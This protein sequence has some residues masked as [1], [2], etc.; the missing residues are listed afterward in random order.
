M[1]HSLSVIRM[2]FILSVKRSIQYRWDFIIDGLLS[3][4][5]AVLQLLPLLVLF[6]ERGSI[7]G[8]SFDEMLVLMGWYMM[9]TATVEGLISPSLS[10]AM[11]GI[12]TGLFDYILIRPVDSLFLCSL[13]D[14]RLWKLIDFFFGLGLIIYALIQLDIQPSIINVAMAI[15]LSIGGLAT[16]YALFILAI[17][18]SFTLIRIQNLTNVISSLLGFA[19]WPI[20]LFGMPW[21]LIFSFLIPIGVMTSAPVMALLGMLNL[22]LALGSLGIATFFFIISRLVWKRSLRGYRSASS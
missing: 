15:I 21:R 10:S 22:P 3:L 4:T 17:A 5:M 11:S 20:H 1:R 14:I 12:R 2:A 6:N 16:T 9:L 13:I 18:T 8:W 7:A 19:R